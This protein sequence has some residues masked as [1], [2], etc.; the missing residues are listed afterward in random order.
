MKQRII[1]CTFLFSLL[2]TACNAQGVENTDK[3]EIIPEQQSEMW[4]VADI[5]GNKVMLDVSNVEEMGQRVEMD[6]AYDPSAYGQVYDGHY[7]YMLCENKLY[8]I[9]MDHGTK[10]G[11]FQCSDVYDIQKC[12]KYGDEFY[13]VYSGR[14]GVIDFESQKVRRLFNITTEFGKAFDVS[15]C[16]DQIFVTERTEFSETYSTDL[17]GNLMKSFKTPKVSEEY[18][19][20]TDPGDPLGMDEK[21]LYYSIEDPGRKRVQILYVNQNTGKTGKVFEYTRDSR[22]EFGSV[23]GIVKCGD[24]VY[25]EERIKNDLK[26]LYIIDKKS[27]KM[28]IAAS[29]MMDWTMSERYVF[30]MDQ[31][32]RIHRWDKESGKDKAISEIE[33]YDI[34]CAG[35][36]LYVTEYNDYFE[37]NA[38]NIKDDGDY[39]KGDYYV[40]IEMGRMN[41]YTMDF[42]GK[43]VHKLNYSGSDVGKEKDNSVIVFDETGLKNELN[44]GKINVENGEIDFSYAGVTSLYSQVEEGHY[45]YLRSDGKRN[46]TIYRDKANKIGTF[47]LKKGFVS[48]FAVYKGKFYAVVKESN[49]NSDDGYKGAGLYCYN[50]QKKEMVKISGDYKDL[51]DLHQKTSRIGFYGNSYYLYDYKRNKFLKYN[52][53]N[54]KI[55]EVLSLKQ[56]P[57][58]HWSWF[59]I[60]NK[61]YYGVRDG[62]ETI[63]YSLDLKNGLEKEIFRFQQAVVS[64]RWDEVDYDIE[65]DIDEDYIY[66]QD[67]LIPRNGGKMVEALDK[68]WSLADT[69]PY[70]KNEKYI[71]Y[72][73]HKTKEIHRLDKSTLEDKIISDIEAMDVKCTKDGLYVQEYDYEI[74]PDNDT[75]DCEDDIV[76]EEDDPYSCNLYYM[77]FD[78]KNVKRLWKGKDL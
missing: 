57:K 22:F 62:K 45:Y 29:T 27:K 37:E 25:I 1:L 21:N 53:T 63:L 39:T 59:F 42:E 19:S 49:F 18:K 76:Q 68:S 47:S 60:D 24:T 56:K 64:E 70:A 77:D 71:F 66:C 28:Q 65:L 30:Y 34:N 32:R 16:H 58:N 43:N 20:W 46:Y 13:V 15:I 74:A 44:L 52:L 40:D 5:T 10:V 31:K 73:A 11:S 38:E 78:G 51:R 54:C 3:N 67:Y 8:T 72:I 6:Y 48:W 17:Q 41:K 36:E 69:P 14:V 50:P 2:L 7:Y 55:T 9:Y 12:V 33:A 26:C 75:N 35:D 23:T 61:L 4:E